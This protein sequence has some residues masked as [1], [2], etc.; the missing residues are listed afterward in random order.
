MTFT[1]PENGTGTDLT[2]R[3]FEASLPQANCNACGVLIRRRQPRMMLRASW[4]DANET[5][6]VTCWGAVVD[7]AQRFALQQLELPL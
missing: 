5:L 6:C 2:E 3:L 1:Y 4:R 7:W